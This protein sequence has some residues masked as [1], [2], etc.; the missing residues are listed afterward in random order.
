M[1]QSLVDRAKSRVDLLKNAE[2]K[3]QWITELE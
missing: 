2:V 3:E 1:W